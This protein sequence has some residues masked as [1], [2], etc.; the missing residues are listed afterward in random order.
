MRAP[1]PAMLLAFLWTGLAYGQNQEWRPVTPADLSAGPSVD[2][3][4]DAAVLFWEVYREQGE[5]K[6]VFSHYI[7]IKIFAEHGGER[8]G[9]VD[10]PYGSKNSIKEIAGRS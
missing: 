1:L 10:L 5:K 7:R 2:Q 3:R 9:R 8:Q 4:A 6:T